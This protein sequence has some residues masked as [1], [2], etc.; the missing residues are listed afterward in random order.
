MYLGIPSGNEIYP[1]QDYDPPK[2][3]ECGEPAQPDTDPPMCTSCLQ[4]SSECPPN[5]G[6]L[7]TPETREEE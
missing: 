6:S 7:L 2:L 3:C 1:K 4:K 5:A